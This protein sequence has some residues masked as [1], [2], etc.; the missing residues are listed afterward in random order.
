MWYLAILADELGVTFEQLWDKNIR[1]LQVRYPE[2]YTD[3]NAQERDTDREREEIE[4]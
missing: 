3:H 4:K 1:K 2:K